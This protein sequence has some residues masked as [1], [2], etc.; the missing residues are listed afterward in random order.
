MPIILVPG[1]Y[2]QIV[3][4]A[5][6]L[7]SEPPICLEDGVRETTLGELLPDSVGPGFLKHMEAV[8]SYNY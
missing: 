5:Q 1:N 4:S 3:D 7:K 8:R 2:L 6:E